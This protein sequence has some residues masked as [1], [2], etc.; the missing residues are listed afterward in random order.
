L[1]LVKKEEEMAAIAIQLDN[2]PECLPLATAPHAKLQVRVLL[3]E[4]SEEAMWLVRFSLQEFGHGRYLLE[5]VTNL[6]EGIKQ[7]SAG[8]A[9]IVL[10]DLGLPESSGAESYACVHEVAPET[11]VVVLTADS[12]EETECAVTAR[13]AEGYLIKDQVSGSLLLQAIRAALYV[14][15]QRKESH[16]TPGRV[17]QPCFSD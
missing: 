13:G 9:D 12:R 7:L 16:D 11:P 2:D 8:V 3:I 1:C 5:W 15:K 17:L 4:D 10:L 14:N 6:S